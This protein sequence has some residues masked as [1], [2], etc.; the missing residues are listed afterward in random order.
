MTDLKNFSFSDDIDYLKNIQLEASAGTGKTY[1]IERIVSLLIASGNR[2]ISGILIVTFTKKAARELKER[3]RIILAEASRT[4]T[5]DLGGETRTLSE[6]ELDNIGKAVREFEKAAIFTIHGFC[7]NVLKAFPFESLSQFNLDLESEGDITGE[8]VRDYLREIGDSMDAGLAVKYRACLGSGSFE[9]LVAEL[10][11]AVRREL[12]APGIHI[13]PDRSV[14]D[15]TLKRILEFNKGRGTLFRAWEKMIELIPD[16]ETLDGLG[17]SRS[18]F[19]IDN[20]NKLKPYKN[21]KDLIFL[22]N[23]LAGNEGKIKEYLEKFLYHNLEKNLKKGKDIE[24][25]ASNP[26]VKAVEDFLNLFEYDQEDLNSNLYSRT[27]KLAFL[28][29]SCRDISNRIKQKKNITGKL[30]F[31]DLIAQL[32][33]GL[34]SDGPTFRAEL[35]QEVR[36]RYRTVLIDEFQDT[37]Q[38]QWDIFST[39]FGKDRAHNFFLVGDPKQSIYRFRGADLEVY[40]RACNSD[41]VDHRF[42]LGKNF[43]SESSL[44]EAVNRI[45]SAVFAPELHCGGTEEIRFY[46]AQA[47]EPDKPRIG[48]GKSAFEFLRI[49]NTEEKNGLVPASKGK[50]AYFQLIAYKCYKLLSNKTVLGDER[51]INSGD[52]AILA[53]NHKDC[54]TLQSLLSKYSIPSII[55]SKQRIFQTD[56]ARELLIFLKAL[57]RMDNSAIKELLLSRFLNFT[58]AEILEREASG[59]LDRLTGLLY[60]WRELV[61][62]GYIIEATVKLMDFGNMEARILAEQNGERAYSNYRQLL[63]YLH[64]EQLNSRLD[65]EKL[66]SL[67]LSKIY[68]PSDRD[69]DLIRLDKDSQAVQIMTMHASKGLEF[70]I[71]FFA[72][73]MKTDN[74]PGRENYYDFVNNSERTY[75]FLKRKE[76]RKFH[77]MDSWEERKRL[78]YVALTRASSRLYMPSVKN[79]ELC[80]LTTLYSSLCSDELVQMIHGFDEVKSYSHPLHSGLIFK[81][82][83][84]KKKENLQLLA[85]TIDK[86][87]LM[88]GR[89]MKLF[90]FDMDL[91]K[92]YLSISD[93]SVLIYR[94][95]ES[96]RS[97]EFEPC[98]SGSFD[99]R[100]TRISSYSSILRDSE[101]KESFSSVPKDNDHDDVG[102]VPDEDQPGD[103]VLT[104][105]PVLGELVHLL[106]EQ[107]DYSYVRKLDRSS[108]L[109]EE[110][111]VEPLFRDLSI[112][113]FHRRWYGK[114]GLQLKN[115][116]YNTLKNGTTLGFSLCELED[117]DRLHEMEFHM[118]VE[119]CE[120]LLIGSSYS[121]N[122]NEGLLKGFVDLI[123]YKNGKYFLADWKT[124]SSPEGDHFD[125]YR[126]EI[127]DLMMETHHYKLQ[128]MIYITALYRYLKLTEGDQF[129]FNKHFG[130]CFYF[131]VRGM[132]GEP[133]SENGIYYYNPSEEELLR[134]A[135]QFTAMEAL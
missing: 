128:S 61:D 104:R 9:V 58:P 91:E 115:L 125:A 8:A 88:L 64:T 97:L 100:Y 32:H 11:D 124:T 107:L 46:P 47:G 45:F 14:V 103:N 84:K 89:D 90:S 108:F 105:G 94:E 53:E 39:L 6:Q 23:L 114:F 80:F 121:G 70:P 35:L 60:Q 68:E 99:N 38:R 12:F 7:L 10:S 131:F 41:L 67:L 55:N 17:F 31:N 52:I 102:L 72:G 49:E 123:F 117:K 75:D 54:R 73:A 112:R 129:D 57:V 101:L 13:V 71:V 106:F 113:F 111:Y 130:G 132:N 33:Q 22:D 65:S 93:Q 69:E 126:P 56:E 119:E 1:S 92:E 19:I 5:L 51:T 29:E 62:R 79:L 96:N 86:A 66:Y 77:S 134:F 27:M 127:L 42:T 16:F 25:A 120:R 59:D 3:I 2:D 18:R 44:V 135:S 34:C 74:N 15:Q 48:D 20:L 21:R 83:A 82:K 24:V 30:D 78:Y 40:Y 43:R 116:I 122:V 133:D 28:R 87:V 81:D 4:G 109:T 85:E 50:E 118:T 36:K 110:I 26:F 63:E 37:D 98:R 76:N 95:E